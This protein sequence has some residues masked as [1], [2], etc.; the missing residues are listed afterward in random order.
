MG[1]RLSALQQKLNL[2]NCLNC[3]EPCRDRVDLQIEQPRHRNICEQYPEQAHWETHAAVFARHWRPNY[4]SDGIAR[5]GCLISPSAADVLHVYE[6]KGSLVAHGHAIIHLPGVGGAAPLSLI[7]AAPHY[8]AVVPWQ[9]EMCPSECFV[10]QPSGAW[11]YLSLLPGA[12]HASAQ[13]RLPVQEERSKGRQSPSTNVLLYIPSPSITE[14]LCTQPP[15]IQRC[16]ASSESMARRWLNLPTA[17]YSVLAD[18]RDSHN[19]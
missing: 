4:F 17:R 2:T 7:W 6:M 3:I 11:S 18:W 9:C 8:L 1:H 13:T 10:S 14:A 12:R 19:S 16:W 15:I 5:R